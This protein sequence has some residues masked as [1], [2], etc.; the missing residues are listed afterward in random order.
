MS[1]ELDVFKMIDVV[2]D[3]IQ[4]SPPLDKEAEGQIEVRKN[5]VYDESDPEFCS[6]DTY[7]IP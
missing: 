7:H 3:K 2:A 1:V 5:I 4:N 6:F